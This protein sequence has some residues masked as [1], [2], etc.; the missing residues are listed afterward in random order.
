MDGADR[1][2]IRLGVLGLWRVDRTH[3]LWGGHM[4]P[5]QVALLKNLYQRKQAGPMVSDSTVGCETAGG[6]ISPL[7]ENR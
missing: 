4:V 2:N 5:V 1:E 6:S 7:G 3:Y